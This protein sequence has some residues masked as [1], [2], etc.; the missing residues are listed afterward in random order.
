MTRWP[1]GTPETASPQ[2]AIDVAGTREFDAALID[3]NYSRDTTSGEEGLE[4]LER[5]QSL[6]STMP[7]MVMTAWGSVEV[8]VQAMRRGARDFIQKPWEN[9]RLLAILR[10][11]IRRTEKGWA[12][13]GGLFRS[14]DLGRTWTDRNGNLH[15][16]ANPRLRSAMG[17]YI[18]EHLAYQE[19][20]ADPD[21]RR[22][23]AY[24][25]YDPD[26]DAHAAAMDGWRAA[27][28]A[29]NEAMRGRANMKS[30][31]LK[32]KFHTSCSQPLEARAT[33]GA[34]HSRTR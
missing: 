13:A 25:G 2:A 23:M 11:Q 3:L 1:R 5:L 28:D 7:V 21:R 30:Q 29:F 12:F 22:A 4:L 34:T 24:D 31:M 33:A 6:D 20:M 8:A 19:L 17:P 32:I 18:A 10:T 16:P 26:P 9:A 15:W 27:R 14:D